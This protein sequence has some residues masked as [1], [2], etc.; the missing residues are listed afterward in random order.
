LAA[1][2]VFDVGAETAV[3]VC[4]EAGGEGGGF[5]GGV[6]VCEV[7]FVLVVGVVV[8]RWRCE[9]LVNWWDIVWCESRTLRVRCMSTGM[10]EL[11]GIWIEWLVWVSSGGWRI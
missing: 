11:G 6:D 3:F 1:D 2:A 4:A 10:M 5:A 7:Y 9:Y 8:V